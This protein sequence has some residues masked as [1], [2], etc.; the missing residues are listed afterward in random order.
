MTEAGETN[1][2]ESVS[3]SEDNP[4]E[5][6][7]EV[8]EEDDNDGIIWGSDMDEMDEDDLQMELI[9]EFILSES[10]RTAEVVGAGD[11]EVE[12]TGDKKAVEAAGDKK[13]VGASAKRAREEENA[14][15]PIKNKKQTKIEGRIA[16][17]RALELRN[18]PEV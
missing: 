14:E 6:D 1:A 9:G 17:A 3:E 7:S 16:H 12:A 2:L 18:A 10:R 13:I 4:E 5:F 8:D 11:K 15:T